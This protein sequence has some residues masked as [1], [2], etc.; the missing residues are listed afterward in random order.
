[1]STALSAD[2]ELSAT[3]EKAS[4]LRGQLS[5]AVFEFS[6]SPYLS[7]VYI[8]VFA[9]YFTNTVVGDSVR[10]QELWSLANTLVGVVVA[11]LAPLIG[12]MSDRMGRRK[13]WIVVVALIMSSACIALWWSMPAAQGGL[14][15]NAILLLIVVLASGF[16]CGEVFH[17]SMLPSIASP[18]RV[19]ALSGI[20]LAVGNAGSLVALAVVLFGIA[21]PA[22]NVI[23]WSVL[24]DDPWFGLDPQRH[25]H[26]RIAGP[27]AGIWLLLFHLPLLWWT[28]DRPSTGVPLRRAV[29]EGLR[30]LWATIKR[31]RE[32]SNVG[33]YLLARMLY[34]DG[35]VAIIAYCGIYGSGVFKWGVSELVLFGL[36]LT[37][38][39][40][41]GGLLG[42]WIDNRIG[43]KRAIQISVGG[44]VV[45]MI[46]IVSTTP[47]EIFFVP[48]ESSAV[49]WSF[50]YFQTL[51][52][53]LYL[54]MFV[55]LVVF[56]GAAF[57]NSRAMLARIAPV[58]AMSQ[59]FGLYA[60]S[61]TATAFFGH[62]LVAFFTHTFDSQRAGFASTLI[63]L[64][65]GLMVM[66][67]VREERAA[68]VLPV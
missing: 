17:N 18:R 4:D 43:S 46:G 11:L 27:I 5:W 66:H 48:Y 31:A 10:G 42:G 3:G 45:S 23:Q 2:G 55:V 50:P 29:G 9:P 53:A 51:P 7:L 44:C 20:G 54:G 1:V 24:P 14:P 62:G 33:V 65:A 41:L 63:L 6:R 28:P 61:G 22:S 40:I 59:F 25:E 68:D 67:W 57:A 16:M 15:V 34:T 52:E 21:L 36:L 39:G 58:S 64:T 30:Q 56:V 13:P 26:E 19:G 47:G 8:Y 49:V 37:P 35:K 12:A 32:V 60:L 38:P